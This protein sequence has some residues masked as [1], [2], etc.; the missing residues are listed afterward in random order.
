MHMVTHTFSKTMHSESATHQKQ[1]TTQLYLVEVLD[2]EKYRVVVSQIVTIITL[3]I[4]IQSA[5]SQ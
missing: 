5:Y 2:R 1:L 3:A 4:A